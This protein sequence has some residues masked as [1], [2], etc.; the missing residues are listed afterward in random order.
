MRAEIDSIKMQI[1]KCS[2]QIEDILRDTAGVKRMC[3]NREAEIASQMASNHEL[4]AKNDQISEE[5]KAEVNKVLFYSCR[6]KP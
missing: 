4:D 5:N 2:V 6:L 1:H 3:D